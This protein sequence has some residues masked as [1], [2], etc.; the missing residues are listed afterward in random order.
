MIFLMIKKIIPMV[1]YFS[2]VSNL[3]NCWL[4]F[5]SDLS[6]LDLPLDQKDTSKARR[7]RKSPRGKQNSM[8][9]LLDNPHLLVFHKILVHFAQFTNLQGA[10][11]QVQIAGTHRSSQCSVVHDTRSITLLYI[12]CC[13]SQTTLNNA[14]FRPFG[15]G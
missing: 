9:N 15:G 12:S 13:I 6:S 14:T 1:D 4:S 10:L 5:Y 3:M 8:K 11:F 2:M 7:K